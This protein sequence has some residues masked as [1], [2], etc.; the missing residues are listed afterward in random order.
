MSIS[1]VIIKGGLK[2]AQKVASAEYEK[3][4]RNRMGA[5]IKKADGRIALL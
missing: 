3:V 1:Y 5:E 4:D 2:I